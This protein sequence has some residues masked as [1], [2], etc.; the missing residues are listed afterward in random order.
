MPRS[1]YCCGV[2][3]ALSRWARIS[4]ALPRL[5]GVADDRAQ[6]QRQYRRLIRAEL[7]RALTNGEIYVVYQPKLCLRAGCYDGVETLLRWQH[8]TLGE[9]DRGSIVEIAESGN[10]IHDISLWVLDRAVRDQRALA[11]AGTALGFHVNLSGKSLG[12]DAFIDRACA[13]AVAAEGTIGFE[14]TETA[15]IANPAAALANLNRLVDGGNR[16]LD[17]RLWLGPF[18]AGLSEGIARR[19][20]Q[21]RQAVR[22]RHDAEQPRPADRPFDDRSRPRAGHARRRRRGG[23][24]GDAGAAACDGLRH[25][26]GFLHQ[27]GAAAGRARGLPRQHRP[28]APLE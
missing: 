4:A 6:L 9:V 27:P 1:G 17:R 26:P 24:P 22:Q 7:P 10:H 21:D 3:E 11:E 2:T 19:R 18:V 8:P 28:S 23:K 14:I 15:F 20:T 16:D 25:G 13:L 5:L 12:N